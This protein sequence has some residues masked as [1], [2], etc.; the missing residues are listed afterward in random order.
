M[1]KSKSRQ[2]SRQ[3]S[4]SSRNGAN[5]GVRT[6]PTTG[7]A[8]MEDAPES[9][10][11]DESTAT[12]A[13]EGISE[14]TEK[15]TPARK[16]AGDTASASTLKEASVAKTAKAMPATPATGK[17]APVKVSAKSVPTTPTLRPAPLTSAGA[18]GKAQSRDAAKYERRV[19]ERQTR[20]LAERR[21]RRNR[22]LTALGVFLAI[23]VVGAGVTYF[24]YQARQPQSQ[25]AAQ[26]TYQESIF[27][28]TYPPVDSVYCDQGEQGIEHIHVQVSMYIDG[29]ASPLPQGVGIP[30]DSSG[31][32]ICLYWLHTHD[33]TGVI[34][35]ESPSHETFTFGQ[36]RDEWQQG[37]ISLG[38]PPELLLNGWK[39][40][41]N[42]K[43][44][45]GSL[46]DIPLDAHNI[47]TLAYNSPNVKPA[48][49]YNWAGL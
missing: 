16:V 9:A 38:F 34:H 1:S 41:I 30:Q 13:A 23:V 33:S 48:T 42:G 7:K 36:F 14:G 18:G 47:I 28:S 39:I 27:N 24:V 19:A 35:I 26:G 6:A 43:V 37:F 25:A 44:Y 45:N 2:P 29:K 12:V 22:L 20:Y 5:S 11:L 46:K 32:T 21:R 3:A 8:A 31:N 4:A 10:A 17:L 49:T 15:A 40:W